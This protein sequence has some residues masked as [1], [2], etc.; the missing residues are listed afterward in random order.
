MSMRVVEVFAGVLV[1]VLPLVAA[2][3]GWTQSARHALL[4]Q[5]MRSAPARPL[6]IR[7]P[8]TERVRAP[9]LPLRLDPY[10]AE[11]RDPLSASAVSLGPLKARL[12]GGS[13]K[14]HIARYKLEGMDV[15][16]GSVSGTLDS[17]GARVYLRWPPGDEDD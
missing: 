17:R 5:D 1:G 2:T 9:D 6:I 15:L 14:A 13:K 16:G 10:R 3:T 8:P 7:I 12:G 4:Q 11:R